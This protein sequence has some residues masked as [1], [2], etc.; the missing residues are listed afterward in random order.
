MTIVHKGPPPASH[1]TPRQEGE[2]IRGTGRTRGGGHVGGVG[3]LTAVQGLQRNIGNRATAQALAALQ[4]QKAEALLAPTPKVRIG[5]AVA[6][7]ELVPLGEAPGRFIGFASREAALAVSGEAAEITIVV[8]DPTNRFHVLRTSARSIGPK[9]VVTG[10]PTGWAKVEVVHPANGLHPEPSADRARQAPADKQPEAYRR[11]LADWTHVPFDGIAWAKGAESGP[12]KMPSDVT[13]GA[14]NVAKS[15]SA[16]GRHAPTKIDPTAEKLPRPTVCI[17]A[18]LFAQGPDMVRGTLLHESR[19]AYYAAQAISLIEKWR[20]RPGGKSNTVE[21]WEKWLTKQEKQL[22]KDVFL[23][24]RAVTVPDYHG[25]RIKEIYP[26]MKQFFYEFRRLPDAGADPATLTKD[27]KEA[28][29]T[30]VADK[31]GVLAEDWGYQTEQKKKIMQ[32]L[33]AGLKGFSGHHLENLRQVALAK[34]GTYAPT[35]EFYKSLGKGLG[36]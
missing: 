16:R 18:N 31:L 27:R 6:D 22:P 26:H 35:D 36:K 25:S 1:A 32:E 17:G 21:D 3:S 24:V 28:L 8:R 20:K 7:D 12:Y 33:L 23:N 30:A 9:D 5:P 34:G 19:H 14:V 13:E 29:Q 10:I 2:P 4:R 11:L 15:L